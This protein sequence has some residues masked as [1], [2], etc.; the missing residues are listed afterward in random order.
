MPGFLTH[1]ASQS[2]S[3]REVPA[4]ASETVAKQQTGHALG[5]FPFRKPDSVPG[6]LANRAL[7]VAPG[8]PAAFILT[9]VPEL[10]KQGWW[11]F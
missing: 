7:A 6:S 10:P 8:T 5:R 1:Q 4:L 2:T 11:C 9:Q 3:P